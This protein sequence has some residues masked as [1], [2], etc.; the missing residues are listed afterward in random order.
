MQDAQVTV[1]RDALTK[2]SSTGRS[3]P[4]G[5]SVCPGAGTPLLA[6]CPTQGTVPAP[7][8]AGQFWWRAGAQQ[9]RPL[10]LTIQC[11]TQTFLWSCRSQEC[12]FLQ[13]VYRLCRCGARLAAQPHSETCR[14][15]RLGS[16]H[17]L[18][19]CTGPSLT[20]AHHVPHCPSLKCA[21]KVPKALLS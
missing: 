16:A 3:H 12:M 21:E 6:A 9:S 19:L 17:A 8:P 13:V 11:T 15:G 1:P 5:Q 4:T 10:R 7:F 18:M 14:R 2:R 20:R